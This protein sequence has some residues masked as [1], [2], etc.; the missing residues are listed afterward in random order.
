MDP[1]RSGLPVPRGHKGAAVPPLGC[2]VPPT[3]LATLRPEVVATLLRGSDYS[4]KDS[5]TPAVSTD[6]TLEAHVRIH[7]LLGSLCRSTCSAWSK[8][9]CRI[10]LGTT[11]SAGTQ[12]IFNLSRSTWTHKTASQIHTNL[13]SNNFQQ[14]Q[15]N[16]RRKQENPSTI[17]LCEALME[18]CLLQVKPLGTTNFLPRCCWDLITEA[19]I[20]LFQQRRVP[21]CFK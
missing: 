3:V 2:P 20:Q 6:S 1:L 16:T 8:T 17:S 12:S 5:S 15:I 21:Q 18:I 7:L 9:I 11:T 10:Y 19:K 13:N 14:R 4:R